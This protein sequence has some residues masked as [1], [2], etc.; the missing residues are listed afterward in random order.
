MSALLGILSV[1]SIFCIKF[2]KKF[3]IALLLCF[4]FFVLILFVNDNKFLDF[5]YFFFAFG[6]SQLVIVLFINLKEFRNL[7]RRVV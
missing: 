7:I 5:V 3:Y 4:G 2:S 6:I 1:L